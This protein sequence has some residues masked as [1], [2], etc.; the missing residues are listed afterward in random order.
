[1]IVFILL[2]PIKT[3]GYSTGCKKYFHASQLT[4][5]SAEFHTLE[6]V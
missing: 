5:I 1:M 6:S 2:K 3:N 4:A